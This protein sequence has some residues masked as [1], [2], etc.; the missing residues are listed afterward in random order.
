[1]SSSIHRMMHKCWSIKS[2]MSMM[3]SIYNVK[4]HDICSH[5]LLD[6]VMGKQCALLL[7]ELLFLKNKHNLLL[8][9][10]KIFV[11]ENDHVLYF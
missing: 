7:T 1:M 5:S 2:V 3:H 10:K 11:L 9:V 4:I 6:G 8:K